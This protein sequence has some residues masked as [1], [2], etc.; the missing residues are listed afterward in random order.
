MTPENPS[1]IAHAIELAL[2]PVFLLTGISALLGVMTNRLARIIDR[3]RYFEREWSNLDTAA[4][5]RGRRELNT[6]EQRRRWTNA[7]IAAGTAAALLICLV[8]ATLFL[9][10]LVEV[11]LRGLAGVFF[12]FAMVSLIGALGAFLREIVLATQTV[13]VPNADRLKD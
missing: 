6:L 10:A 11:R 5:A 12:F 7:S 4:K 1:D 9:E 3:G 2:A 8:V 13:G